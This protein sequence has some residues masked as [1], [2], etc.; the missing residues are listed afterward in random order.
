MPAFGGLGKVLK[1]SNAACPHFLDHFAPAPRVSFGHPRSHTASVY[2]PK[3]ALHVT[4]QYTLVASARSQVLP[5]PNTDG[6]CLLFLIL[7][8]NFFMRRERWLSS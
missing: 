3:S 1:V 4:R 7:T 6:L 2:L 5:S 8:N